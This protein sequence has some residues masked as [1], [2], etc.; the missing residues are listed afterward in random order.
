MIIAKKTYGNKAKGMLESIRIQAL[1]KGGTN[2]CEGQKNNQ[3]TG[4]QGKGEAIPDD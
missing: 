2:G 3:E 1:Y 4:V